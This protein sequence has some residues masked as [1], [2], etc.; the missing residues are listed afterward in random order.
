[1]SNTK[2][3]LSAVM[4]FV[5]VLSMF[6]GLGGI[7]ANNEILAPTASAAEGTS[8]I[9]FIFNNLVNNSIPANPPNPKRVEAPDN[10]EQ[11]VQ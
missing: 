4:A 11:Y 2:R 5:M 8:K 3:F 9:D 7:F 1:M 10:N 6:S